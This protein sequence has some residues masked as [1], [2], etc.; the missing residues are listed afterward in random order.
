MM[1]TRQLPT[2][3]RGAAHQLRRNSVIA[4]VVASPPVP[5]WILSALLCCYIQD[6]CLLITDQT[7]LGGVRVLG[8]G[9]EIFT[10]KHP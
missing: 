5:V 2:H 10:C 7:I 3:R 4:A 6:Q 9:I 8:A 1:N